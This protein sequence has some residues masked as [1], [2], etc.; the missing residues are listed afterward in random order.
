MNATG[1][2]LHTNLGRAPLAAGAVAAGA[3][4]A[5]GYSD[6]ELDLASGRRGDRLAAVAEKLCLLT[7][8]PA[9]LA[10]NNNAAALLLALNTL[11]AR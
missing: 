8:A 3:D 7:D 9:A 1:I 10:V 11:V 5:S 6:L 4:A 2:V